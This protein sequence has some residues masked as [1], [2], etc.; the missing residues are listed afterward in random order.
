MKRFLISLLVLA[1]SALLVGDALA[2]V[3]GGR[4][5]GFRSYNSS[6]VNTPQPQKQVQQPATQPQPGMQAQPRPSFFSSPMFRMIAGGLLIGSLFS[7]FSG[8]GF[9]GFGAPGLIEILLIGGIIYF[10][11]RWFARRKEAAMMSSAGAGAGGY[12]ESA[13]AYA[14]PASDKSF[15][16]DVSINENFIKDI[17]KSSFQSVQ[18]AWTRG[19]LKP[20]RHLMTDRM[21]TYLEDQLSQVRASGLR[22]IVEIVYFQNVELVETDAE[23]EDKVAVVEIDALIRDYKLDSQDRV[24]EGSKD[25]P[26]EIREYWAFVGKGLDWKLDDIK[27][28]E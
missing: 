20:V 9:Q 11:Y 18:S 5:S 24:V 2:R 27:Q 25:S 3:G 28:V 16:P 15:N 8:H 7:M 14:A 23:N 22:N 17:A 12:Q 26:F 4:S 6:R 1:F 13:P 21:F 19:D 10:I